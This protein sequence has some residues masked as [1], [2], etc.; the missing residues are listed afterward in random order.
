MNA[1]ELKDRLAEKLGEEE[2]RELLSY[3]SEHGGGK[4]AEQLARVE[5]T[6]Q[7]LKEHLERLDPRIDDVYKTQARMYQWLIGIGLTVFSIG[8]AVAG[9]LIKLL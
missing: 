4:Q 5:A 6:L 1:F 7:A 3:I 8:I 9:L 2:S